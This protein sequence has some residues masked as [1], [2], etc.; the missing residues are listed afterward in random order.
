MMC[1]DL[2][3]RWCIC[4]W[5]GVLL[6][7]SVPFA[8]VYAARDRQRDNGPE[9]PRRQQLEQ[10]AQESASGMNVTLTQILE[11]VNQNQRPNENIIAEAATMLEE[12]RRYAALYDDAQKAQYMLLQA[13]TDFY[14]GNLDDAMN[15]SL[16]ACRTD[17]DSRDAWIS[18]AV[19]CQLNGKRPL[20]PRIQRPDPRRDRQNPNR[21]GRRGQDDLNTGYSSTTEPYGSKGTL[22]FGL[23]ALR[24]EMLK[25]RFNRLEY[26]TFDGSSVEYVP[27]EDTLCIFFWQVEPAVADSNDVSDSRASDRPTV[28]N[29]GH[30][31][32]SQH[33][34]PAEQGRY[35]KNLYEIVKSHPQIS[36][37]A[38]N[39]NG[40][41]DT[42]RVATGVEDAFAAEIMQTPMVIA[43]DPGSGAGAFVGVEAQVPFM[44]IADKE[45]IVRYAGPAADFMPAFILSHLTGVDIPLDTS[46]QIGT[47]DTTPAARAVNPEG[48]RPEL[49]RRPPR[50]KSARPPA[51]PNRPGADPN[52]VPQKAVNKRPGT[53]AE[54]V[55]MTL[56]DQVQADHLLAE[57][58]MEIEACR[59]IR[60]KSPEK[61]IEACK[62][63]L[64]KY[65]GTK[66]AEQARQWLRKVPQ[67]Y[68]EKYG[69]ADLL[70]Y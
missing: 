12:N 8:G 15:W 13:W 67:R 4:L 38:L 47:N 59:T 61:G 53:T 54:P 1:N 27:G 45:G 21:R 49:R 35:F 58:Q 51:D 52:S 42:E 34:N 32:N 22:E 2:W 36:C 66:Y 28:N 68:W 43:A 3:N 70:G 6:A 18:Q 41:Q 23:P 26:Q 30:N 39:T 60:G 64:E 37:L 50:R 55:E 44:L 48:R 46:G 25:E 14:Q 24:R 11:A 56:A 17:A 62:E 16:R 33:L 19:F 10:E 20:E 9:N 40:V 29:R 57:A 31:N 7:V 65:P 5:V 69:I 63:V